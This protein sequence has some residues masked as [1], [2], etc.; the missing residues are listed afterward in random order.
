MNI[1]I[2]NLIESDKEQLIKLCQEY[3]IKKIELFGSGTGKNFDFDKSDLDFLVEFK[4]MPPREYAECFMGFK[5]ALEDLFRRPID[6]VEINSIRNPYF[7]Q[8]IQSNRIFLY[9]S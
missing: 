8:S 9:A 2:A 4:S 3:Q 7:W 5:L 6:L 1:T